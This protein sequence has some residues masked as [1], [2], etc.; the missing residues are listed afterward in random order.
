MRADGIGFG[1]DFAYMGPSGV[2]LTFATLA[3]GMR[4]PNPKLT[5]NPCLLMVVDSNICKSAG[6]VGKQLLE[7]DHQACATQTQLSLQR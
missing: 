1:C 5:R 6:L 7:S 3:P 2:D 4:M